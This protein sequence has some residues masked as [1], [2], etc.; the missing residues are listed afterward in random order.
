MKVLN[1]TMAILHCISALWVLYLVITGQFQN[2]EGAIKLLVA[3]GCYLA[4]AYAAQMEIVEI[5]TEE[6]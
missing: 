5:E 2:V 6:E 4:T 1:I 3:C